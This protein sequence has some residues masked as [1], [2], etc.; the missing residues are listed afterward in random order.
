MDFLYDEKLA[1]SWENILVS[2]CSSAF[3]ETLADF[4]EGQILQ[5]ELYLIYIS[6]CDNVIY[7]Q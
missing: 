1:Q 6:N 4:A 3:T 7:S 2:W 5:P